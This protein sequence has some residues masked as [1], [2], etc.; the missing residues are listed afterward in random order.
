MPPGNP[1]PR[2]AVAF[3]MPSGIA[4]KIA[5]NDSGSMLP[6][7][8]CHQQVADRA[9]RLR[10]LRVVHDLFQDVVARRQCSVQDIERAAI[11]QLLQHLVSG[12]H[13]FCVFR[14]SALEP[15]RLTALSNTTSVP[16]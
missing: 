6:S 10:R 14:W 9:D 3:A 2:S 11:I 13:R 15:E 4:R 5:L 7:T 1:L 16:G 8:H 12:E